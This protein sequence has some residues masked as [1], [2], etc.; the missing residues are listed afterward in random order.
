MAYLQES[1]ISVV[2]QA[3]SSTALPQQ[4]VSGREHTV[5]MALI[6]EGLKKR[7]L[8]LS[9]AKTTAVPFTAITIKESVCEFRVLDGIYTHMNWS[10]NALA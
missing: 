3:T 7:R 5:A 10:L 1:R 6:S 4:Q 9:L 8:K 2:T